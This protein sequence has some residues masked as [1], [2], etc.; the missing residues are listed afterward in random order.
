MFIVSALANARAAE[1]IMFEQA[2]CAWCGAFNREI[3]PIYP[4][5]VEGQRAPA[6]GEY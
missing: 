2:G 4:N 6:S 1:L 5:T 3:G